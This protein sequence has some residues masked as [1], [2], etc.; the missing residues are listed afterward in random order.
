VTLT[1]SGPSAAESVDGDGAAAAA[2]SSFD[3]PD[4]SLII[5]RFA[6]LEDE[7]RGIDDIIAE[8]AKRISLLQ[9]QQ[10]VLAVIAQPAARDARDEAA[11]EVE[12]FQVH[13]ART[14]AARRTLESSSR[15]LST[16][17]SLKLH[18]EQSIANIAARLASIPAPSVYA[19]G[20]AE[21]DLERTL[22]EVGASVYALPTAW[23]RSQAASALESVRKFHALFVAVDGVAAE[24]AAERTNAVW[25]RTEPGR[26]AA[27]ARPPDNGEKERR[28][29][30]AAAAADAK[31]QAEREALEDALDEGVA[32]PG[33]AL[34]VDAPAPALDFDPEV[35]AA[36]EARLSATIHSLVVSN[37]WSIRVRPG[38]S[39]PTRPNRNI[40]GKALSEAV[41]AFERTWRDGVSQDAADE[42]SATVPAAAKPAGGA[43]D[44][45]SKEG[46]AARRESSS[47][48]ISSAYS[49]A[50]AAVGMEA[51]LPRE[52]RGCARG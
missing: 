11:R 9:Q 18:L 16:A 22:D 19:A 43:V 20:D 8:S 14:E 34:A 25:E 7:M 35:E 47:A 12:I 5:E 27:A 45:F 46:T 10:S 21:K 31:A 2:P 23:A 50:A 29:R 4:P 6:Q 49:S 30:E 32:V 52:V 44:P 42:R 48:E 1:A 28:A 13:K 33:A 24:R 39:G 3:P 41:A 40:S 36:N 38:S 51:T 15:E 26:A 17:R 37:E